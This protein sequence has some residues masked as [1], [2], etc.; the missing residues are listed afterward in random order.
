MRQCTHK[1]GVCLS[2]HAGINQ[3]EMEWTTP[4]SWLQIL[5]E[6]K[7][8]KKSIIRV[9]SEHGCKKTFMDRDD[10]NSYLYKSLMWPWTLEWREE[11]VA[12]IETFFCSN[13]REVIIQAVFGSG[14]TTMMLAMVHILLIQEHARADELMVLAFN[15]AIKNEIRKKLGNTKIDVRTYDSLVYQM[16]AEMGMEDLKLPN[17]SGKRRFV[18]NHLD[19]M[20]AKKHIR[21]VFVD[22]AQDLEKSCYTVMTK[23]YPQAKFLFIG[24]IFQSIQKEPRESLLW[25]LLQVKHDSR[26]VLTMKMTPR[27]PSTVLSEISHALQSFYPEFK[28]TIASWVSG[29]GHS[30]ARICWHGFSTYKE[31]YDRM[32]LFCHEHKASDIMI[33]TFSSAITVR[34]SLGDVSRVRK[35]LHSHGIFTNPNH[36]NMVPDRVFLS[37]ANSSKGLERKHVFCFLTF[38]LE[39]AF[40]NF[41]D[42][43]VVN[44][45][46]VA[47]SRAID[48]VTMYVPN[49]SD[50]FSSVLRLYEKCPPPSLESKQPILKKHRPQMGEHFQDVYSMRSMLEQEH[51]VTELLRQNILSFETKQL[52]RSF[53][54]RYQSFAVP[55]IR[56]ESLR[57]EEASAFV[58]VL[59][60][61]LILSTW[62]SAWPCGPC[63]QGDV[64]QHE[65]FSH[66]N[67]MIQKSRRSYLSFIKQHPCAATHVFR[68]CLLYAHLHISVYH[69]ISINITDSERVQLEAGWKSLRP[70]V[71]QFRPPC[72]LKHLKVQSNVAMAFVTGIADSIVMTEKS[73]SDPLEIIEIKASRSPNWQ[74]HA[75]VQ[76]V[77]YGIM[78]GRNYFRIHLMNVMTKTFQSYCVSLKDQVMKMRNRVQL[79]CMVWNTNCFLAKNVTYHDKERPTMNTDGLFLV[80][81]REEDDC[82]TLVEMLSPTKIY[83]LGHVMTQNDVR[84]LLA[85]C[86]SRIRL[87]IVSRFLE[88][89]HVD[90]P[91]RRMS[92]PHNHFEQDKKGQ[93][94]TFMKTCMEWDD[95]RKTNL[96]M[97]S[98]MTTLCVQL[99]HLCKEV[100]FS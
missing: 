11:Q 34:G 64:V 29:N 99:C 87:V 23:R 69:K 68:G 52:L 40:A 2:T 7:L 31:V 35:F 53:C 47:L 57:T 81:G 49:H 88:G 33:L 8:T 27:V 44:I 98:P 74:E 17:F 77:I 18:V 51:G 50:R 90:L 3:T 19:N 13:Y 26:K 54:K 86:H 82:Y 75:L 71:I 4:P 39:K 65:V 61:S 9:L 96:D 73:S 100:N 85:Q 97:E 30:D 60:E 14:K 12:A 28:N 78:L 95:E 37:T 38:P 80:D 62:K 93:W 36:K 42:D 55:P 70:F 67:G 56:V 10:L 59:F 91:M 16:C 25:H 79:D 94:L 72:D 32:L 92:F 6:P 48:T 41:S 45:V 66:F 21:Y 43:L 63:S 76:S 15:V 1:C 24:D 5:T 84:T 20:E 22:E 83:V 46:T 58:G 89:F